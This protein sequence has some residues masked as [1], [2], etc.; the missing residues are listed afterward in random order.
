M[1]QDEM[2]KLD[3]QVAT[4]V[5]GWHPGPAYGDRDGWCDDTGQ[6]MVSRMYFLPSRCFDLSANLILQKASEWRVEK[7]EYGQYEAELS[8]HCTE[9]CETGYAEAETPY[10][11]ICQAALMWARKLKIPAKVPAA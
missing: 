10:I 6:A 8:F 9:F 7:N 5:M 11:A 2:D 3:Y 1:T 4:E